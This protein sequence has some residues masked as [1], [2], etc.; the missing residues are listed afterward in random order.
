MSKEIH[1]QFVRIEKQTIKKEKG[2]RHP[3]KKTASLTLQSVCP[4]R[5]HDGLLTDP[6]F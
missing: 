3:C 6:P 1:R 4:I 5:Q 2:K